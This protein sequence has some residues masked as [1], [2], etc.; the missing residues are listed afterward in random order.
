MVFVDMN[1]AFREVVSALLGGPKAY[2]AYDAGS[3]PSVA[4]DGSNARLLEDD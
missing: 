3:A 2:F 1:T 4:G